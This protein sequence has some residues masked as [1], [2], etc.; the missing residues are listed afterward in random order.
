MM[1]SMKVLITFAVACA[2]IPAFAADLT[3][4]EGSDLRSRADGLVS[5]RQRNP[6]WD[7]GTT[8]LNKARSDVPLNQ[9]QGEVKTPRRG[10]VKAK[11]KSGKKVKREPLRKRAKR[12]VKEIP[13]ALAR[14]R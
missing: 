7:G 12:T 10:E 1:K 14:P 2:S 6:N 5:E 4:E 8:R 9:N 3:P 13:G 11:V